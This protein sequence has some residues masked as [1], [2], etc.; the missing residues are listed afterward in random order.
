M[1]SSGPL[2]SSSGYTTKSTLKVKLEINFIARNTHTKLTQIAESKC[3]TIGGDDPVRECAFPFTRNGVTHR[4]CTREGV[5]D[6]RPWCS[7]EVDAD[8]VHT[9][10]RGKWGYCGSGCSSSTGAKTPSELL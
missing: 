4:G 5:P 6:G 8:G 9:D 2:N 3:V 1:S 10:G 7:T